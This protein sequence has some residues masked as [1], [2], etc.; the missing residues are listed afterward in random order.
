MALE[1]TPDILRGAYSFLHC[2]PPFR[3]WNLPDPEDVRFKIA[4]TPINYGWCDGRRRAKTPLIAVSAANHGIPATLLKTMAHEMIHLYMYA[5][6]IKDSS[7]HGPTFK[8]YWCQV[9]TVLG[10]DPKDY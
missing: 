9:C 4:R 8:K 2:L 1:L 3:K 6:G 7:E 10:F 5:H